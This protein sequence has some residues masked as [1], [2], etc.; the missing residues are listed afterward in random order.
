MNQYVLLEMNGRDKQ[1]FVFSPDAMGYHWEA[2]E[3]MRCLDA[4]KRE[5]DIVPLSFSLDLMMTMDRIRVEAGIVFPG[6]D[7]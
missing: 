1:E 5:S 3:V 7:K 4:G 6:R 2:E